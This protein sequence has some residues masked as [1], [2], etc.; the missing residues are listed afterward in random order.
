MSTIRQKLVARELKNAI[1][2]NI[3]I[4]GGRVAEK[5]GYGKDAI[6]NP[7]RVLERR[8]VK[9]EL[10]ILGFS[11]FEADTTV[12]QILLKGK[13]D[14]SKLRAADIIYKRVGSYA[15]EKSQS[16]N[17]NLEIKASKKSQGLIDEYE[18][19]LRKTLELEKNEAKN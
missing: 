8:G 11:E 3:P 7:R 6:L 10:A 1:E 16:V 13:K 18:A 5:C 4:T 15:P 12:G 2:N 9:K 14:E 17:L 19:K